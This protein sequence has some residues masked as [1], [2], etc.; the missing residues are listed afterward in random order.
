[1]F[2]D[3]NWAYNWYTTGIIIF[4][5]GCIFAGIFPEDVKG[6]SETSSGK[7]HGIASGIGFLFLMLNPLWAVWIK[8]FSSFKIINIFIFV[9]GILTFTAFLV[10]EK[11]TA[12]ILR[13]TGLYQRLNLI[14]LYGAIV[15]NYFGLKGFS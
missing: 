8:E 5:I 13:F 7:I 10:S 14:L 4:A 3:R 2:I 6:V 9:S 1:M 12:G 11:K 15:M